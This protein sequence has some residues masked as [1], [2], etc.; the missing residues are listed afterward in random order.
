M[1][2]KRRKVDDSAL[3]VVVTGA[4]GF[5]GMHTIQGLLKRGFNVEAVDIKTEGF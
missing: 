3:K 5:I 2:N 4:N 1:V